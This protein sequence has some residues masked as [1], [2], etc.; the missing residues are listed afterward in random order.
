MAHNKGL[1]ADLLKGLDLGSSIAEQDNLLETARVETSAFSDLLLDKIDLIPGTKGSGKSAL[2]RIFVDFLAR[3][4]LTNE[5]SLL[6]MA[7]SIMGTV[8]W[9]IKESFDILS[10]DDFVAFWC[11]YL[12]SLAHEQFIKNPEFKDYLL[13]CNSEIEEFRRACQKARIPEIRAS[14]SLNEVI[15]WVLYI[16]KL[17]R[18]KLTYTPPNP[19]VGEYSLD[20]FGNQLEAEKT[21]AARSSAEVPQYVERKSMLK[22]CWQTNLSLWLMV[23]RLDEIFP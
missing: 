11:I 2:Y 18:P 16:L 20:L 12:V 13:H 21:V 17:W 3:H 6:R 19:D 5:R 15:G 23:D 22:R 9:P 8:F 4:L 10:E 1:L 7:C 14:L